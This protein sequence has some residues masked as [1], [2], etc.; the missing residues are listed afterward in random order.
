M[1]QLKWSLLAAYVAL[2]LIVYPML[3]ERVPFHFGRSGVVDD[4]ADRSLL[5]WLA[6]PAFLTVLLLL[7]ELATRSSV[8]HPQWWNLPEKR[9]FLAL[10]EAQRAP[11]YAELRM[12]MDTIGI[13]VLLLFGAIQYLM[14]AASLHNATHFPRY[15]RA[16]II[17]FS[18]GIILYTALF[19]VRVR[20]LILSAGDASTLGH[21][22]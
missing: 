16:V 21:T 13:A 19:G 1:R 22:S 9:R 2:C 3:P 15:F 7:M 11:I 4:W 10:S 18:A 12:L 14:Y 5:A 17:A 6:L 20:R 8:K